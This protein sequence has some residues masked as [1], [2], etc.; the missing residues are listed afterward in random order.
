MPEGPDL[1]VHPGSRHHTLLTSN[2]PPEDTDTV[3]IQSV[4][5]ECDGRLAYLEDEIL[6]LQDQ[7]K[8]LE[9]ERQSLLLYRTQNIAI[10]SPVRRIPTEILNDIFWWTLPP[11]RDDSNLDRSRFD[12]RNSPWLLTHISPRWRAISIATPSLWSR[13][14]V[15]YAEIHRTSISQCHTPST[16]DYLSLVRAQI[17]RSPRLKIHFYAFPDMDSR[18]Q[19]QMFELL[20]QHCSRWEELSLG[21]AS[22][23]PLSLTALRDRLPSLRRLWLQWD[24]PESVQSLLDCF[25]AAS[26]LV[27][28]GVFDECHHV[29]FLLP[30]PQLTRYEL[31]GPWSTH[32]RIL[33]GAPN[34]VEAHIDI[35]S[36][37]EISSDTLI[38]LQH[39]RR[40]Y[41][42]AP[43]I[44]SVLKAPALEELAVSLY[45]GE[46]PSYLERLR[47][48]VDRSLCPLRRICHRGVPETH[49]TIQILKTF[50]SLT[51]LVMIM[52]DAGSEVSTLISALRPGESTVVA[53]QLQSLLL[54]FEVHDTP[55]W[56]AYFDMLKARW[57]AKNCTLKHAALITRG[58]SSPDSLILDGLLALRQEGLDFILPENDS[59]SLG[60]INAWLYGTTWN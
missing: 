27:E 14:V 43:E 37:P 13:I 53:P 60:F 1:A 32:E 21:L 34:L 54:G 40:L 8:Q 57:E 48:F 10:L 26:S 20:S 33:Q 24:E 23:I 58:N 36:D 30:A 45:T 38:E 19:I 11:I 39:L 9:E 17:Q 31:T 28:V 46:G 42:S 4:I 47:G 22:K 59:E 25:R 12:F 16:A 50:P 55:D 18:P 56:A 2:E 15:D 44:L 51:E 29:P 52:H 5:S 3:F 7:L 49:T 41:I 6:K 35:A